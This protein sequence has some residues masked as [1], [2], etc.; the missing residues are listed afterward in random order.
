[1]AIK[2]WALMIRA[3]EAEV[4]KVPRAVITAIEARYAAG[5][6]LRELEYMNM[7][8]WV[9]ETIHTKTE[10]PDRRKL[11]ETALSQALLD[12]VWDISLRPS[13]QQA[14][15]EDE[16]A[17]QAAREQLVEISGRRAYRYVDPSNGTLKYI[18]ADGPCSPAVAQV[19]ETN[20]ADPYNRVKADTSTTGRMY[21][22]I[23][24]KFKEARLLF[25]TGKNLPPPGGKVEQGSECANIS[26]IS[27]HINMLKEIGELCEAEG[28]TRLFLV[29]EV[30]N[31]VGKWK[32]GYQKAGLQA[33]NSVRA[34]ALK[35]IVLRWMDLLETQK[36]GGAAGARGRRYFFRPISAVKTGHKG[37]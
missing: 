8:N 35:E 29:D 27:F 19:F 30:L 18:C 20:A 10:S 6:Q 9:Y 13:E 23:S 4:A 28:Y 34:C 32:K 3:G 36:G 2:E 14:L 7:F 15:L 25:K 16:L 11:Y 1:M 33:R 5:E 21:G 24:A 22:F 17:L 12:C 26:N 37:K 31:D